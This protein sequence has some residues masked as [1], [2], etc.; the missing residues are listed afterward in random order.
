MR[1]LLQAMNAKQQA[2]LCSAAHS[3]GRP[4]LLCMC[5]YECTARAM[6]YA[7]EAC[8][9]DCT[10]EDFQLGRLC[11]HRLAHIMDVIIPAGDTGC[12]RCRHAGKLRACELCKVPQLA[13]PTPA[14]KAAA[15]LEAH[16]AGAIFWKAC[17][18]AVLPPVG[19]SPPRHA[20]T[21]TWPPSCTHSVASCSTVSKLEYTLN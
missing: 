10:L 20:P 4:W 17:C 8:V 7:P 5:A 3:T 15:A 1:P 13:W 14:T 2:L 16:V 6:L 19:T 11:L 18:T 9:D 21:C 12:A